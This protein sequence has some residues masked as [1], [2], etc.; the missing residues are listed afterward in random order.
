[1]PQQ[2]DRHS[3][4]TPH[5]SLKGEVVAVI[6]Q[7]EDGDFAVIQLDSEGAPCTVAGPICPVHEGESLH[8]HG[9]WSKHPKY[10]EQFRAEWA[11]HTTPTTLPGLIRYLGSGAFPDIGPKM[12]ERLV[13][14]FGEQ[15]LEAL[16]S[17]A[18]RLRRV[19]GIGPKRAAGLAETFL[20]GRDEH[21]ILSELR[22]FG[23]NSG[24][25]KLLFREWGPAAIRRVQEDPWGLISR[26][27]GLGFETAEH[28]ARAVGIEADSPVRIRGVTLHL[29]REGGKQG[30]VCLTESFLREKLAALQLPDEKVR[31]VFA[32]LASE[33]QAVPEVLAEDTWWFLPSLHQDEQDLALHLRRLLSGNPVTVAPQESVI[34]AMER[35]AFRP[36]PSQRHALEV[37][38]REP[39]AVLTGG[40]GTGKTT[41]LRLFL[42]IL[43]ASGCG[44]IHLASPTGR[45]AKRLQEATGRNATTIHRLLGF[46]PATGGFR[47]DEDDPLE[48]AFVIADEVSMM[49]LTLAAGL[50]RAIPDGC[51]VLLVGDADQLPSVGPGSVL[52]DLVASNSIPTVRL[53]EV[54]RQE[55]GSGISTAAHSILRGEMPQ[56]KTESGGDFFTTIREDAEEAAELVELRHRQGQGQ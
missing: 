21:R 9:K 18:A 7:A 26:V 33:G 13:K 40:P 54:H 53:E 44:P 55:S 47:H 6:W 29:L 42:E 30:H 19:P 39:L 14:H 11:E 45:A 28:I 17:G 50:L 22:G 36:D 3:Q 15:T 10:G 56:T 1:M 8:L 46:D 48:A 4:R 23:L 52:R 27:R 41:L 20:Q 32:D 24:Q 37:A 43:E 35:T 25:A 16:E 38:L 12:A 49:D 2:S 34:R 31:E 51:R 5:E